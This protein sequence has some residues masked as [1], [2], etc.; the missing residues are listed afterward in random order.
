MRRDEGVV[1]PQRGSLETLSLRGSQSLRAS[2]VSLRGSQSLRG[3]HSQPFRLN[4]FHSGSLQP[5]SRRVDLEPDSRVSR[6][7]TA[8][9]RE[10]KEEKE[11]MVVPNTLLLSISPDLVS[12]QTSFVVF[13]LVLALPSQIEGRNRF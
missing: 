8:I 6:V 13:S 3:S 4:P 5:A 9:S 12:F 1:L 7:P 2:Q 10:E 11:D